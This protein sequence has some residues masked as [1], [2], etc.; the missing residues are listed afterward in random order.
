[1]NISKVKIISFFILFPLIFVGCL[2]QKST[3]EKEDAI[4]KNENILPETSIISNTTNGIAPLSIF[5]TCDCKDS[6]G[7]IVGYF[8]SFNDGNF[9]NQKNVTHTFEKAGIYEVFLLVT[10]NSGAISNDTVLIEVKPK[11]AEWTLSLIG[12]KTEII[13]RSTFEGF[14]SAYGES[15]WED[16]GNLWTGIPLWILVSIVD[17]VEDKD[18]T[19][20]EDLANL[21]YE[22]K[23]TAGDG[24]ITNLSSKDI[25]ENQG[26]LVVNKLNG[27]PLPKYTPK[28]KPSW[29]LHLRGDEV[30][31]PNNVGNITAIELIDLP[32]VNETKRPFFSNIKYFF[33]NLLENWIQFFSDIFSFIKNN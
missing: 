28:G 22:I 19:F 18:Y 26:Y 29:P 3:V 13:N 7:E 15:S 1:M 16:E 20:N 9:S 24:W 8:W 6:D 25:I 31:C 27:E 12:A 14:V 4:E 33:K 11:I 32:D 23:I 5:F 21:G 10:D 30:V 2:E 17:D